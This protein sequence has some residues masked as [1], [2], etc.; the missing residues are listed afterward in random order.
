MMG[1]A[2]QQTLGSKGSLGSGGMAGLIYRRVEDIAKN[3]SWQRTFSR[4]LM[5]RKVGEKRVP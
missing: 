1:E 3:K 4:V 5:P 2:P